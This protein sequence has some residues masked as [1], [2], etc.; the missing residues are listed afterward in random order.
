MMLNPTEVIVENVLA[1]WL[2]DWLLCCTSQSVVSNFMLRIITILHNQ[3]G[4][5]IYQGL[6]HRALG[7]SFSSPV[8]TGAVR[9]L[10]WGDSSNRR[11]SVSPVGWVV[12]SLSRVCVLL[13]EV[14]RTNRP[15]F[16]RLAL[17]RDSNMFCIPPPAN[18]DVVHPPS[19]Y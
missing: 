4:L 15:I 17:S 1:G 9:L 12:D 2:A 18:P 8:T 3:L 11:Q 16:A 13:G 6:V 10:H 14:P 19:Q 7:R 5:F